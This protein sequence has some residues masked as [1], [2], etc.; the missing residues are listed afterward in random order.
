MST[1]RS[2]VSRKHGRSDRGRLTISFLEQSADSAPQPVN[3]LL[4]RGRAGRISDVC[5]E[6]DD[7]RRLF[8]R[9]KVD[10]TDKPILFAAVA[11]VQWGE[12]LVEKKYK[13]DIGSKPVAAVRVG[14]SLEL[15]LPHLLERGAF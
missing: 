10:V 8:L 4:I 5:V 9:V 1:E 15:R 14:I 7:R 12:R 3:Y 6:D 11:E 13:A 2:V